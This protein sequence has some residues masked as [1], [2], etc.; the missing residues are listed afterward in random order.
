MNQDKP[1]W[2]FSDAEQDK[3]LGGPWAIIGDASWYGENSREVTSWLDRCT[4]GWEIRG[5]VIEFASR[6]HLTMFKLRWE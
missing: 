6:E 4:P 3:W 1:K 2:V 5:V